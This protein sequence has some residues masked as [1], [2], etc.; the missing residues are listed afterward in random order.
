MYKHIDKSLLPSEYGGTLGSLKSVAESWKEKLTQRRDWFIED[1][2]YK[3]NESKRA[4]KPKN[5]ETMFG[6]V[7][8]FRSL[9]FD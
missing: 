2:M 8:S 6:T 9:D 7:G 1:E 5:A 4:G 3:T